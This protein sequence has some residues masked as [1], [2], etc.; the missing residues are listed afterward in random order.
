VTAGNKLVTAGTPWARFKD[1]SSF[2][3]I[4]KKAV[5]GYLEQKG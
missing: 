2:S 4:E 1:L 3:L 5:L